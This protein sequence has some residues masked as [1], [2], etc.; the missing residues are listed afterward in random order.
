MGTKIRPVA[1]RRLPQGMSGARRHEVYRDLESCIS[2]DRPAV[3]LDCSDLSNLDRSAIHLLL[4]CLEEAMKRN[5]DIR[6][7]CVS[8][9]LGAALRNA[10][11]E[12]LFQTFEN[13]SQAVDSFHRSHFD[14]AELEDPNQEGQNSQMNAA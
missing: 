7:A 1:V 5:G 6:L 8:Q 4:C 9:E 3:V 2:V 11:A 10:N 13:V 12:S 14:L